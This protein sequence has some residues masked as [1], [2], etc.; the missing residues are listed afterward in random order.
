[1]IE[2]NY[3][4][5]EKMERE[6]VIIKKVVQAVL[7]E[8]KIVTKITRLKT[9]RNFKELVSEYDIERLYLNTF[10]KEEFLDL[11]GRFYSEEEQNKCGV[12]AIEFEVK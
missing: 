12:V 1:M 4:K 3:N 10:T 8:E 11:L 9:F 2:I 5:I 7:E 6:E